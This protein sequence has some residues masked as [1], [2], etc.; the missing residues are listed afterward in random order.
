MLRLSRHWSTAII[1]A[2]AAGAMAAPAQRAGRGRGRAFRPPAAPL[3]PWS[4]ERPPRPFA[5]V[6]FE[7]RG[8]LMPLSEAEARQWLEPVDG[9]AM[10]LSRN[11]N[12]AGAP[13]RFRGLAKLRRWLPDAAVRLTFSEGHL[14]IYFWN[15]KEG[16]ALYYYPNP[17]RWAAYRTTWQPGQQPP[18]RQPPGQPPPMLLLATD[19]YRAGR[20]ADNTCEV[21]CQD[22]DVVLTKGDVRILT[23]PLGGQPT[24]VYI[25]APQGTMLRDLAMCR[26]GPAPDDPLPPHPLLLGQQPPAALA[27]QEHLSAGARFARLADG[28]VEL[29]AARG[30]ATGPAWVTLSVPRR[31]LYEV[32]LEV[33]TASP[34]SGVFV[35]A[36]QEPPFQGVEF[37]RHPTDKWTMALG[38]RFGP[39]QA[40][41]WSNR[42]QMMVPYAGGRQWLR[43]VCTAGGAKCW[44]G[45]DGVHWGQLTMPSQEGGPWRY[46]GLYVDPARNL[47][48]PDN[49]TPPAVRLRR[50]Q[51]RQLDGITALVSEALQQE[52]F[53]RMAKAGLKAGESDA[54]AWQRWVETA[55]PADA[56][57]ARW[58]IACAVA[59]LALGTRPEAAHAALEDLLRDGLAQAGSLPS[60]IALLQDAALL[61]NFA[62]GKDAERYAACWEQLERTV[63]LNGSDADFD[64]A[65]RS[66]MA[67]SLGPRDRGVE[68]VPAEVA[69][70][71]LLLLLGGQRW[72]ELRR[73]CG[74]LVYWHR[75]FN[76]PTAWP[77]GY[78]PLQ[79]LLEWV[80]GELGPARSGADGQ[81]TVAAEMDWQRS[82]AVPV[83]REVYNFLSDLQAAADERLFQDVAHSLAT[84]VLPPSGGLAPDAEDPLLFTSVPTAVQLLLDRSPQIHKAMNDRF[85]A[86]D[87]LRVAQAT[88]QG[89]AAAVARL[90]VQYCGTPAAAAAH[91][92]LGDRLM[93]S[94]AFVRA[95]GAYHRAE[96]AAPPGGHLGLLARIR[97]AAAMLGRDEGEPVRQTVVLGGQEI[98]PEEFEKWVREMRERARSG[99]AAASDS[100]TAL[101]P[102]GRTC[103]PPILPTGFEV[104]RKLTFDGDLGQNQPVPWPSSGGDWPA[105]QM[106]T[107][108][109][110]DV[111]LVSNRFQLVA[112]EPGSGKRR[113]SWGLG[114]EQG[115]RHG[116]PLLPMRPVVAGDR[117]YARVLPKSGHPQIVCLQWASGKR[118]WQRDCPG[119][120][121][122]D[123]LLIGPR[124]FA[125]ELESPAGQSG[126]SSLGWVEFD[127][128][129]GDVIARKFLLELHSPWA[130][131]QLC[132]ATVVGQRVV[133]S[134]GGLL[135][136]FDPD[137]QISWLRA[138]LAVPPALDPS[139]GSFYPEPPLAADGRIYAIQ[140][141]LL[142]IECIDVET[143]RMVWRRCLLGLGR[144]VQLADGRLVVRDANALVALRAATGEVLWRREVSSGL[145]EGVAAPGG[146]LLLCG[147]QKWPGGDPCPALLWLDLRTGRVQAQSTLGELRNKRPTLG[148]MVFM[149]HR[150]WCFTGTKKDSDTLEPQRELV[151]LAPKGPA[152]PPEKEER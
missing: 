21:R 20:L 61:W 69:R 111:L 85:T 147:G 112:F 7:D 27:W 123:P 79:K 8:G 92:W 151:E 15:G 116:W 148:P 29:S 3:E 6:C 89:D 55:R 32:L 120:I 71:R 118:L 94:G 42:E 145:M 104:R 150:L 23:A 54:G 75:A 80:L 113:W 22:G 122:S 41:P 139:P 93:S 74:Q 146:G 125:L 17:S 47:P 33:E 11:G 51:V 52:A 13:L 126:S 83:N 73:W 43:L 4:L 39:P 100:A 45:G 115:E 101:L 132:Q 14:R 31:G 59:A 135:F 70:D 84:S 127:R 138:N 99:G 72:D 88:A 66:F 10:E 30:T 86:A 60:R 110:G 44:I 103:D 58:R 96:S 67:V 117:V 48:R 140:S 78:E 137:E 136:A 18:S 16:I 5:E 128:D 62:D 24:A 134:V 2:L 87:Q 97:L 107:L 1:V 37:I 12:W 144:I 28:G 121:L 109:V 56:Q 34:G 26:S 35:S 49:E 25:E 108:A 57:P 82:L 65:R 124:M 64:L 98:A 95:L 63:L 91:V 143:G 142:S 105:R 130:A 149:N 19:D 9:Q 90:T 106:A 68:C 50:V 81:T 133:A 114:G 77:A 102:A 36:G 46:V 38:S 129:S 53:A 131:N 76:G 141:G 119:D 152:E 40:P